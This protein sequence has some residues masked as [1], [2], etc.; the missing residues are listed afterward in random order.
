MRSIKK[1]QQPQELTDWKKSATENWQPSYSELSGK[2]KEAVYA[3]LLTEQ[4]HI[5]CYCERELRENDFHLEHLNPQ[6]EH[7]GD[8]LNFTNF[9]CSCLNTTAKGAPLH[10]GKT[11]ANKIISV[12]PLQADCQKQFQFKANG[13]MKGID[14]KSEATIEILKLNI[15][16]LNDL[17]SKVLE[18]FLDEDLTDE[19]IKIFVNRYIALGD[20][21]K[22]N[23]FISAV[24]CVFS[25]YI[26][27]TQDT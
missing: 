8:D 17:R 2:V 23:P 24:E 6:A 25:E 27:D 19:E 14:E 7:S 15:P 11:K 20:E 9:L 5:C 4:G 12:H 13:K 16:K 21:G 18:V 22:Y 10:C 26:E 1:K 3:A